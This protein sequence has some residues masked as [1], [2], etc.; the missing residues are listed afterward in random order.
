M[1]NFEI[2]I[3][4]FRIP[5]SRF[6]YSLFTEFYAENGISRVFSWFQAMLAGF[7]GI[8]CIFLAIIRGVLNDAG[9]KF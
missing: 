2:F 8:S 9:W 5:R 7:C 1:S 4:K 6:D 3:G